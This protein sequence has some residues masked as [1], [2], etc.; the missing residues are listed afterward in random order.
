MT[1][2]MFPFLSIEGDREYSDTDFATFYHN[3]FTNGIIAT[4]REQLRVRETADTGMR[5]EV[6]PG[7]ILIQ[8]RQYLTTESK[9]INVT[10]GSSSADR[11]DLIVAR[12]DMME[13]RISIIYKQGTTN[14]V[15]NENMWEMQLARLNIPRN[16]T[17]V[18]N[19]HIT[20]TR[21][22]TSLCGYS[23]MSGELPVS[24][25]E[26]QYRAMLQATFDLFENSAN[27]NQQSL[28]NLLSAQQS[29]FHQWFDDLQ[30]QLD[31]NQVA[32][33][34][35]QLNELRPDYKLA[36]IEHNL[37][38][39]PRVDGLYWTYGLGTVDLEEQPEGV[40][41]DGTAPR[42][43]PLQV[44]HLSR[45]QLE[46]YLP[47]RYALADAQLEQVEGNAYTFIEGYKSV[48]IRLG[49]I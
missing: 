37:G 30:S 8:G 18:F 14:L 33:L 7:A 9:V 45:K 43:L 16:A 25:L 21:A 38:Y 32:N 15:R 29:L 40:D 10:P 11:T 13:R 27:E 41:W 36:T 22:N 19:Q 3:I 42:S 34:Q 2:F 5:V 39:M 49:G 48:Q 1:E 31:E 44:V 20:D 47:S 24:G 23:V 12:L 6:M 4:V 35:N 28:E 17:N 46:V 26:D